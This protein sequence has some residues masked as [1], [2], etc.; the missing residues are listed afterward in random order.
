M[1]YILLASLLYLQNLLFS[2]SGD[3]SFIP[4]FLEF[5]QIYLLI[6]IISKLK[7]SKQ[8]LFLWLFLYFI[9]FSF[10][11]FFGKVI[12]QYDIYL[13]FTHIE[14]TFETFL[15]LLDIFVVPFLILIVSSFII[16]IV[17]I[18]EIKI[19]SRWLGLF[20]VGGLLL[21]Y[22][23]DKMEDASFILIK[24]IIKSSTLSS[25]NIPIDKSKVIIKIINKTPDINIVLVIGESMRAKEFQQNIFDIFENY[26]YKSIYSGG[27]STDVSIPLLLNGA[28][29]PQEININNNIFK[30]AKE[31]GFA[32]SFISIQSKKSL[33]YIKPYLNTKYINNLNI[34]ATNDDN[35]MIDIIKNMDTKNKTNLIVIQMQGQHS[36][37]KSYPNFIKSTIPEQYNKTMEY[38]NK[39]I[40]DM[41]KYIKII[42]K[43]TIFIFTSDH[44]ELI[45][46][47]GSYGH[48]KFEKE[49]YTV[50][51]I[52]F[53]NL[54]D[55]RNYIK[56]I[57]SHNDI[58]K[59]IV[60]L[61]GYEVRENLS[62][63]IIINGSMITGEDGFIL[64]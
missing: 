24:S 52:I 47:N 53:N 35:N 36:P 6:L 51:L 2:F 64:K 38:S 10:I 28:I 50:P 31:N 40:V 5:L 29:K 33:K 34:V 14:E 49:I 55:K 7:Y 11:N 41:I 30:L 42:Q 19:D 57:R 27:V 60:K 16:V 23:S 37:Y 9:H 21:N 8:I 62:N 43:Q 3:F 58:Y 20:L 18:K 61:L 45:G 54:K 56:N 26:N 48:N 15:S 32:T 25:E 1:L 12:T 39:I 13:F 46:L 22:Q 44:G 63:K 4:N 59:T 17:N